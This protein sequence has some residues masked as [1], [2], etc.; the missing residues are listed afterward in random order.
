MLQE[1]ATIRRGTFDKMGNFQLRINY[2]RERIS[3]T[4]FKMTDKAYTW[5]ALKGIMAEYP[6]LYTRMVT[7][8]QNDKLSWGDLMAELQELAV[9]EGTQPAMVNVKTN[10]NQAQ[11]KP[12]GKKQHGPTETCDECQ[13]AIYKGNKHCK[14]CNRHHKGTTCWWCRPDL[15]PDDWPYKA[16][17]TK[18]KA[19]K[20]STTAPLHQQ[21]GPQGDIGIL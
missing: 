20:Q 19:G 17:A 5:L 1:L 3:K 6:D 9:V 12:D 11:P 14:S 10:N 4:E 18:K 21:S 13:K 8:I 2:L 7:N 16:E 15:A